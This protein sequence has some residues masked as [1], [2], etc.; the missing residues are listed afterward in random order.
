MLSKPISMTTLVLLLIINVPQ[1]QSL[2]LSESQFYSIYEY[3]KPVWKFL[4]SESTY[5]SWHK[6]IGCM[7]HIFEVSARITQKSNSEDTTR[8]LRWV[9]IVNYNPGPRPNKSNQPSHPFG[10]PASQYVPLF[11]W[12]F[13]PILCLYSWTVF[14]F[15]FYPF[16]L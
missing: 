3:T 12:W 1:P 11:V 10:G 2:S 7:K 14:P 9:R 8:H 5:L 6:Q 15:L 13:P 16:I 4:F